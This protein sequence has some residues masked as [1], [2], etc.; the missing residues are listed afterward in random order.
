M[1]ACVLQFVFNYSFSLKII[2]VVWTVGL[3]HDQFGGNPNLIID[4]IDIHELL[5]DYSFV[6][7]PES[8]RRESSLLILC[9]PLSL[10]DANLA[11]QG[12]VFI[13]AVQMWP[14]TCT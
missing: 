4:L 3:V 6:R 13:L 12:D 11:K 1:C 2:C 9:I 14:L 7:F 8:L 10:I 5:N